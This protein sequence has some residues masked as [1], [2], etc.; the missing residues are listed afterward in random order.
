MK[1]NKSRT[2]RN[3]VKSKAANNS[4]RIAPAQGAES[5][6][7]PVKFTTTA[8]ERHFGNKIC[9]NACAVRNFTYLCGAL[10]TKGGHNSLNIAGYFYTRY[11]L[12]S[13]LPCGAL[14]RPLPFVGVVQR[15]GIE[16]FYLHIV[17]LSYTHYNER[18]REQGYD[19]ALNAR[20]I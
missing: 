19:R 15:V 12:G 6:H 3:E 17:K 4:T 8:P 14:M 1:P 16:P 18:H 9:L 20:T 10:H 13:I 5:N 11:I 7:T 2:G